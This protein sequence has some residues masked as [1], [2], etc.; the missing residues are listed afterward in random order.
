MCMTTYG[1]MIDSETRGTALDILKIN[2]LDRY[3]EVLCQLFNLH[4]FEDLG[5]LTT[6]K[7]ETC[8]LPEITMIKLIELCESCRDTNTYRKLRLRKLNSRRR[9]FKDEEELKTHSQERRERHSKVAEWTRQN[10][11]QVDKDSHSPAAA[12]T[13]QSISETRECTR[14]SLQNLLVKLVT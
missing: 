10:T 12:L 6:Q 4:T 9:I 7:I 2:G 13:R 8:A 14:V 5:K 11:H 1:E 3:A